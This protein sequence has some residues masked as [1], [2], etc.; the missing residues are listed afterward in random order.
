MFLRASNLVCIEGVGGTLL[1]SRLGSIEHDSPVP[2]R[3]IGLLSALRPKETANKIRSDFDESRVHDGWF[4]SNPYLMVYIEERGQRALVELLGAT[5]PAAL[6]E[7]GDLD[8]VV[9]IDRMAKILKV[10]TKTVRRMIDRNEIPKL[11]WAGGRVLRFV[12]RDVIATLE[13]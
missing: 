2:V 4:R 11:S 1:G 5:N 3:M 10:S 8:S 12:P 7:E 13:S 9:T 6:L